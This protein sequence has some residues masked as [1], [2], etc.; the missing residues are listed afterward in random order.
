MEAEAL[1]AYG[2]APAH[3]LYADLAEYLVEAALIYLAFSVFLLSISFIA[4]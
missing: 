2:K 3:H 1:G 4:G